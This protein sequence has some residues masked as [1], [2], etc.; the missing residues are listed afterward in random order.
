[1]DPKDLHFKEKET[2]VEQGSDGPVPYT[3]V[4]DEKEYGH[5]RRGLKSRHVQF[6]AIGGIIGTGLF[7]GSGAAL[8]RAGPLSILLAY[9]IVGTVIYSLMCAIGEMT[10]WLPIP[11]G[12]TIYAHRYL[13]SSF[14]FAMGWNYTIGAALTVC[15]EVAAAL[16]LIEFWTTDKPKAAWVIL[17]LG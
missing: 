12:L 15:A 13:D 14:G 7:V 9:T 16:T 10:T 1:M 4:V 5:V 2:D 11:G 17:I 3:G 8:V 6:I